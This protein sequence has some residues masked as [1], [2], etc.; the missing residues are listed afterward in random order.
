MAFLYLTEQG[1]VLRKE[2]ERLVV[3]KDDQV[4]LDIPADKVESVLLF[5]NVQFTTQAVHLLFR[6]GVEMA[7]FTSHGQ[8]L[9]QL[10]SSFPGN[11]ALRQAQYRRHDDGAFPLSFARTIV[12]AK[13]ANGLEVLKHFRHNHPEVDFQKEL[14]LLQNSV[15]SVDAQP[16]LSSILGAEGHG[17]RVYFDG[18]ARM[19]RKTFGFTGRVKHPATDP[20]NA[21][22]SLGYTLVYK[23]IG[24]LLDGL[25]FDP[26][27]GFFHQPR[28][29][30]ATLASDLLEEF[31]APLVDRLTLFLVNDRV[32]QEQD[33]YTHAPSGGIHLKDESRKRYFLHYEKAIT[34]PVPSEDGTSQTGY[35][36]LFLRQAE[37]LRNAVL[38]GEPYTPYFYRW[39]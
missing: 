5:G 6:H 17:A 10:T 13:L 35:R 24:S 26:Y 19:V 39:C 3:E 11:V 23:E 33:F 27:L 7:L 16:D 2:G 20:V 22:L 31:R 32:L 30:H 12:K 36:R 4:L 29:G 8:L 14:D 15:A 37:R 9:G 21:L 1:S 28:H 18:F 38:A 34:R 25:G